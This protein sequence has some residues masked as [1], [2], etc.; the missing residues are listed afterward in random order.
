MIAKYL[1]IYHSLLINSVREDTV[2]DVLRI[3]LLI[4]PWIL[5][6]I[7]YIYFNDIRNFGFYQ[8]Y[9]RGKASPEANVEVTLML[10]F[11]VLSILA[12]ILQT[13]IELDSLKFND[14]IGV[15]KHFQD[16]F[17]NHDQPNPGGSRRPSRA[18]GEVDVESAGSGSGQGGGMHFMPIV[19][20]F[21]FLC[22][23]F[24]M[25]VVMVNAVRGNEEP[26]HSFFV[27]Y[28]SFYSI[29]PWIFVLNHASIKEIIKNSVRSC[30]CQDPLIAILQ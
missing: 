12:T 8:L 11:F 7:E 3:L 2:I 5:T 22:L 21:V 25:I 9:R 16:L 26:H 28:I 30:F 24:L 29:L 6:L 19:I 20:R 15:I 18:S 17:V 10:T 23:C 14:G 1:S 4:L 27:L 13:R